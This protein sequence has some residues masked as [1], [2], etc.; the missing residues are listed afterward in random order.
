ML[1]HQE[2]H[3][4]INKI[5]PVTNSSVEMMTRLTAGLWL[6]WT[7]MAGTTSERRNSHGIKSVTMLIY[8]HIFTI[9]ISSKDC[10]LFEAGMFRSSACMPTLGFRASIRLGRY[11]T[12]GSTCTKS[13]ASRPTCAFCVKR[14]TLGR[15]VYGRIVSR[16]M[17]ARWGSIGVGIPTM[18]KCVQVVYYRSVNETNSVGC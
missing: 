5:R 18:S 7:P 13:T 9:P 12:Y 14:P 8:G 6:G 11:E 10:V 2:S 3:R 4:A 1:A 15:V 16:I 17:M